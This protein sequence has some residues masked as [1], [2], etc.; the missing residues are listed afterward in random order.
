MNDKLKI[1]KG[2]AKFVTSRSVGMIIVKAVKDNTT[3]LNRT[4]EVQVAIGAYVLAAMV[5]DHV[6]DWTEDK[7]DEAVELVHTL[8]SVKEEISESE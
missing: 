8:K 3:T 7:F 1:A 4:E 2:V 6:V 5:C